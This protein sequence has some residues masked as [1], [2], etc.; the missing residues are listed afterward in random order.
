MR[1]VLATVF[2]FSHFLTF[3]QKGAS[4]DKFIRI[5]GQSEKIINNEG[6]Y[7]EFTLSEVA[8]NEYS[9]IRPKSIESVKADFMAAMKAAGLDDSKMRP[10]K[11][12]NITQSKY[13]K[14][15]VENFNIEL[16]NEE[17]AT[18]LSKLLVDGYKIGNVKYIFE[19]SYD[20]YLNQ[21]TEDAIKDARR[22]AENIAKSVDKTVGEIINIEDTKTLSQQ[23]SSNRYG[24]A[25]ENKTISYRINVTFELN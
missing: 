20:Q 5:V 7:I 3:A 18:K 16:E 17:E 24:S 25:S 13:N 9:Q 22:K 19:E 4:S 23:S 6:M 12:K 8:G 10:D 15:V 14:V 11:I 2:I 1:L 21:M